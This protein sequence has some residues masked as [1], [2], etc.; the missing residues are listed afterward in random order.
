MWVWAS[1][2]PGSTVAPSQ[3]TT[4]ARGLVDLEA[5]MGHHGDAIGLDE[6]VAVEGLLVGPARAGEHPGVAQE[7]SISH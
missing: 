3:S 2:S 1:A 7:R 6:H 5:P 4:R